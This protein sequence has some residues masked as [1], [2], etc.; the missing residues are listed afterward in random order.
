[1]THSAHTHSEHPHAVQNTSEGPLDVAELNERS[2]AAFE[3]KAEE[4]AA[5]IPEL[6][7]NPEIIL[8]GKVLIDQFAIEPS[9]FE[10][11]GKNVIFTGLAST[12]LEANQTSNADDIQGKAFVENALTLLAKDHSP[13]FRHA[14]REIDEIDKPVGDMVS[15]EVYDKYTNKELS[16][17]ITRL[18]DEG[19][20]KD[21]KEQLGVTAENEYPYEVCVLDVAD[22]VQIDGFEGPYADSSLPYDHPDVL[23]ADAERE[24]RR[25]WTQQLLDNA[26][27]MEADLHTDHTPTAWVSVFGDKKLLCISSALAKKIIDPS[28]VLNE[29]SSYSENEYRQDFGFLEHEYAHTQEGTNI[30]HD[31][32]FGVGLEERRAEYFSGDKNGYSDTKN[33]FTDYTI[34]TGHNIT[35]EFDSRPLGGSASEVFTAIANQ[36]SLALMTEFTLI[37]PNPYKDEQ[38]KTPYGAYIQDY[39]GG[40]DGFEK[41]LLT[42]QLAA[43][44]SGAIEQRVREAAQKLIKFDEEYKEENESDNFS[45]FWVSFRHSHGL[46]LMTDIIKDKAESLAQAP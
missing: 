44:Q 17:E 12:W 42:A 28:T 22:D 33:F 9:F 36:T 24:E 3:L 26:K 18:I 6:A 20:L 41:K 43:G 8:A 2:V 15:L 38:R 14:K 4:L 40:Y 29:A 46:G 39:I 34:L 30:D 27:A 32:K 19:L 31:V 45:D 37:V 13:L 7:Q 1:M 11:D 25:A 21:V 35:D 23:A 16:A 10:D 5:N